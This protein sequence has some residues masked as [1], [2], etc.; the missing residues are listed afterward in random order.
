[1]APST[2]GTAVARLLRFVRIFLLTPEQR[3]FH[4]AARQS[5]LFDPDYYIGA[6]PMIH[7]LYHR[8]PLRHYIVF[9]EARGYRPNADFSPAAYLHYN[10]DVA[11]SGMSPFLHWVLSGHREGRIHKELPKVE[12]LPQHA[13]PPSSTMPDL[14]CD[15]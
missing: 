14:L 3:R 2:N 12:D 1:M 15:R 7:P 6:Y 5:G 4:R 11:A 8:F 9:G 13:A 10:P